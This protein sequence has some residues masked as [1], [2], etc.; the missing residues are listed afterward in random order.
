MKWF[1]QLLDRGTP[2]SKPLHNGPACWI[3]KCRKRKI[4]WCATIV[5]HMVNYKPQSLFPSSP[6]SSFFG[7]TNVRKN[8]G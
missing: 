6:P 5:N 8:M 2:G 7:H 1:G 3:G 4:Q